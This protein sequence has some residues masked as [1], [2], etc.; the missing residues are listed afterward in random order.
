MAGLRCRVNDPLA[1]RPYSVGDKWIAPVQGNGEAEV[2]DD[3][4][5]EAAGAE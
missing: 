5:G 2:G 1:I 4:D 3:E